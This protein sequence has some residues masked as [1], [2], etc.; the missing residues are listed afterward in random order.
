M[1]ITLIDRKKNQQEL[2]LMSKRAAAEKIL[3]AIKAGLLENE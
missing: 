2:G 1:P 3:D